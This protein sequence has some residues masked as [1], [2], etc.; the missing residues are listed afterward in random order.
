M[1]ENLIKVFNII[2]IK[3]WRSDMKVGWK[4]VWLIVEVIVWIISI[5]YEWKCEV[6]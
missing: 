6:L 5:E 3:I 2:I 4:R 1:E